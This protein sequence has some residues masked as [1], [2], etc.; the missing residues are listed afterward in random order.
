[1]GKRGTGA[2]HRLIAPERPVTITTQ[3]RSGLM[4]TGGALV[5]VGALGLI[6]AWG[7][8]GAHRAASA[9]GSVATTTLPV[10]ITT[11]PPETPEQF[12][13]LFLTALHG[14]SGFLFDRLDPVVIARYGADQCRAFVPKLLDPAAQLRLVSVSGPTTYAW[15]TEGRTAMVDSVYALMVDGVVQGVTGARTYHIALVDGRFRIFADCGTPLP[16]AP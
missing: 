16:G 6:F 13:A 7:S 1:M 3:T 9:S 2:R 10:T 5:L 11:A 8:T 12:L 15:T 14:D 4:V